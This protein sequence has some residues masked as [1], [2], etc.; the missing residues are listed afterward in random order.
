MPRTIDINLA[1]SADWEQLPTI[2]SKLSLRIITFRERL[3]GFYDVRQVAETFGISDSAFDIIL[4][5]LSISG[6]AVRKINLNSITYSELAKHPYI[7]WK[8]ASAII[9]YRNEHG[10]Y[11]NPNDLKSIPA[12]DAT[13]FDRLYPYLYVE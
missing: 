11:K 4:P 1:D 3:G 6:T 12:I 13:L 5:F 8:L 9:N 10:P 7:R 2:G